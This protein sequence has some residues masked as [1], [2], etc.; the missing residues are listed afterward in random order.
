VSVG[1]ASPKSVRMGEARLSGVE[2]QGAPAPDSPGPERGEALALARPALWRPALFALYPLAAVVCLTTPWVFGASE[3]LPAFAEPL[4]IAGWAALAGSAAAGA[5]AWAWRWPRRRIVFES[6]GFWM[7]PFPNASGSIWIPYRDVHAVHTWRQRGRRQLVLSLRG[8]I[9]RYWSAQAFVDP[10]A[11]KRFATSVRAGVARLPDGG[12]R[13]R[14][15]DRRAASA[16]A[17]RRGWPRVSLAVALVVAAVY[18]VE[19]RLFA[20]D[21]VAPVLALANGPEALG[22]GEL[23]RLVTGTLL[24]GNVGH[25]VINLFGLLM[26]GAF[27]ERL[28]G[29]GRFLVVLLGSAL[30]GALASSALSGHH[31]VG[32]SGAL[33][34]ALACLAYLMTAY[35]DE[36]PGNLHPPLWWCAFCV[37]LGIALGIGLEVSLPVNIDHIAHAGGFVA[38][39]G[40]SALTIRGRPLAAL[41]RTPSRLA[42]RLAAGFLALYAGGVAWGIQAVG[43]LPLTERAVLESAVRQLGQEHLPPETRNNAAWQVATSPQA[44]HEALRAARSAAEQLA[45][46]RPS[47][48]YRRDTLATLHFRL[49]DVETAAEIE[50]SVLR[51]QPDAVKASQLARFERARLRERSAETAEGGSVLRRGAG[52]EPQ[53]RLDSPTTTGVLD[54]YA[55]VEEPDGGLAGLAWLTLRCGS[56]GAGDC[57]VRAPDLPGTSALVVAHVA[58]APEGAE[59]PAWRFWPLDPE[60]AALPGPLPPEAGSLGNDGT[61]P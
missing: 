49:G 10:E 24:H 55:L 7:P 41:A 9:P 44:T 5:L 6:G 2:E 22:E 35:R 20:L 31:A 58:P 48:P 61:S 26:M 59:A 11:P 50:R 14:E 8:R 29:R 56:G 3:A 23:F 40:L 36:V 27:C 38:G 28:V 33:Y 37:A 12:E 42:T 16:A 30:G 46:E 47:N 57:A 34:G 54:V 4:R 19:A 15:L 60:V 53:V 43:G 52:S 18:A 32:S 13:L 51:E 1:S 45:R 17:A 39:L 25:L 21:Q